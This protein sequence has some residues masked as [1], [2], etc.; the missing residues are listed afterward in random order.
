LAKINKNFHIGILAT[1]F[2]TSKLT[3]NLLSAK[4]LIESKSPDIDFDSVF[5][6]AIDV[7]FS[8]IKINP[9]YN[10]CMIIE[11]ESIQ[12]DEETGE[13]FV[14]KIIINPTS[15]G[16]EKNNVIV[17][18]EQPLYFSK[19]LTEKIDKYRTNKM[20]FMINLKDFHD[21][22]IFVLKIKNVEMTDSLNKIKNLIENKDHLGEVT[23]N[24]LTQRMLDLL[25]CSNIK[26]DNIHAEV[27]LRELIRDPNDYSKRPDFST[28]R[29]PDYI[30][31][32]LIDSILKSNSISKGLGFQDIKKQLNSLDTYEKNGE[33]ILD[34]FFMSDM[35]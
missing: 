9:D 13:K 28:E 26:M 24:G 21:E 23:I 4:H 20:S 11:D 1:L 16:I 2:L 35:R 14:E 34:V 3:Q 31:L 8:K 29:K 30:I 5:M 18:F 7:D 22:V 12:E 25:I 19:L 17:E 10:G 15:S 27:I 32:R 6:E 33:S